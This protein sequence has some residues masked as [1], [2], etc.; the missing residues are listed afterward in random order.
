MPK[1]IKKKIMVDVTKHTQTHTHWLTK[2]FIYCYYKVDLHCSE[3][4]LKC[5]KPPFLFP[6]ITLRNVFTV[7][8]SPIKAV[9]K[10]EEHRHHSQAVLK[11]K[12]GGE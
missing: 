6:G 1:S 12:G 11:F 8:V 7:S 4:F 2:Y 10:S 9:W 5:Q 3:Q